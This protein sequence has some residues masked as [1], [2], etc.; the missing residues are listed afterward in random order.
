MSGSAD[1]DIAGTVA[2]SLPTASNTAAS[3]SVQDCMAGPPLIGTASELPTPSRS[4][5]K[6]AVGM[7]SRSGPCSPTT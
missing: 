6:V 2:D 3:P 7:N 1:S 4:I 5:G